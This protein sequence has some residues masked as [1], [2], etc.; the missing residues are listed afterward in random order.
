VARGGDATYHGP[1]QLVGYPIVDLSQRTPDVHHYLRQLEQVLIDTLADFGIHGERREGYTGVWIDD[2]RKIA[3]IGIGLRRWVTLHGF[4]LNVACELSRFDAIVPCGL[5]GVK[6]VDMRGVLGR[7]LELAHV[8]E[9]VVAHLRKA[10][11]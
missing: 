2:R 8:R 5:H 1:G 7:E 6:M 11:P 10:F 9:R 3:S 4:A